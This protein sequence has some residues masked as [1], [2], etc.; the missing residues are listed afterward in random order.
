[1]IQLFAT[2]KMDIYWLIPLLIAFF[3]FISHVWIFYIF[4]YKA[5]DFFLII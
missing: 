4:L 1:M 2:K 5:Q 3:L